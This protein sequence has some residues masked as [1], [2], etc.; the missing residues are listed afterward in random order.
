M[1]RADLTDIE[2]KLNWAI[3]H[4]EKLGPKVGAFFEGNARW[5]L[6]RESN[7]KYRSKRPAPARFWRLKKTV[8][9]T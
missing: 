2:I 3:A 8:K 6:E 7:G 4:T 5:T 1:C 9:R